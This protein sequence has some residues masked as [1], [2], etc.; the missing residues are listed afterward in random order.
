MERSAER[1]GLE[2]DCG[3]AIGR[4]RVRGSAWRR[5][6]QGAES[7]RPS[8]E[9][10]ASIVEARS[11]QIG[12]FVEFALNHPLERPLIELMRRIEQ[13]LYVEIRGPVFG[14]RVGGAEIHGGTGCVPNVA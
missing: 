11:E 10:A 2:R 6:T 4:A 14:E 13:I 3:G 7:M 9:I 12:L 8:V 5:Q 1:D